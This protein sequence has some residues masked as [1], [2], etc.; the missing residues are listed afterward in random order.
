MARPLPDHLLGQI[1]RPDTP[2]NSSEDVIVPG[3]P[4]L[5]GESQGGTTMALAIRTP[6]RLKGPPELIPA[7]TL[8]PQATPEAQVG[9]LAST[10]P[11]RIAQGLRKR[12]GVPNKL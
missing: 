7:L 12:S 11:A 1:A 2:E 3:T 8:A 5:A 9:P 4:P 10:A 6:E